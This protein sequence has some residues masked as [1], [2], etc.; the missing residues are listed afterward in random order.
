MNTRQKADMSLI[1]SLVHSKDLWTL[2]AAALASMLAPLGIDVDDILTT[3]DKSRLMRYLFRSGA[4][5]NIEG[6]EWTDEEWLDLMRA[7]IEG[8]R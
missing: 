4:S 7:P 8:K 1:A 3:A 5:Y 2:R 6:A